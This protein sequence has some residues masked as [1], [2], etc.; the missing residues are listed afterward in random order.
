VAAEPGGIASKL[1]TFYERRFAV[2][3]ALRLT[4]GRARRLRWEPASGER[5]GADVEVD[6]DDG[7]TEHVQLRRQN[8]DQPRWTV[9]ELDAGGILTAAATVAA[10][11]PAHRFVFA[12][13]VPAQHL[14]DIC[15]RLLRNGDSPSRFVEERVRD[16]KG[17]RAAF[18]ELL[19]RWSL[20]P[21]SETDLATA[22]ARLG[23]MRFIVLDR[24]PYGEESLLN[25]VRLALSG[26]PDQT[27]ALIERFLEAQL[28]CDITPHSLLEH[29]A[30][31]DVRPRDLTS[32]RAIPAAMLSLRENF[33]ASLRERLVGG[34]WI[35]RSE[36]DQAVEK[37]TGDTPPRII[38]VHGKPGMGKSGVLLRLTEA[39]SA[40]GVPVLPISLAAT[41]PSGNA[42]R[43]GA[44]LGLRASPVSALRA[45]AGPQRAVLLLDQLDAL[46]FTTSASVATWETCQSLLRAAMADPDTV[47]VL[48][49][50]SFDLENDPN[51]ARW[52]DRTEHDAPGGV[53]TINVGMLSPEAVEPVVRGLGID[54]SALPAPLKRLL[55]HPA[56]LDAWHRLARRG[57]VR[58]D[59]TT[60]TALLAELLNVLRAEAVRDH[61][62]ADAEVNAV[63]TRARELM[64]SSGRLTLPER[65]FDD[66]H[67][68][69]RACCAAGLLVLT[70]GTV[71]FPHQSYFDHLV[72]RAALEASGSSEAEIIAWVK[73]DQSLM[74]RDRV[75]QL[76]V[77][78]RDEDRTLA[79]RVTESLLT[80]DAVRFHIKYLVLGVLAEA[81]PVGLEDV[82]L[83]VGLA[84]RAGW[85]DH[86]R[87]KVLWRSV[88]WFDALFEAGVWSG[89]LGAPDRDE[90]LAWLQV[91]CSVMEHRPEQIDALLGPVLEK[92]DGVDALARGLRHP[93]PSHDSPLVAA[94]R[95][96]EVSRGRW[97][98]H[99]VFLDR[100]ADRDPPRA[101]RLVVAGV[102]G[103]LRRALRAREEDER[104]EGLREHS[105][106]KGVAQAARAGGR[107][108][109]RRLA[110]VL[111]AAER[112]KAREQAGIS[113]LDD[114]DTRH[115]RCSSALSG[116]IGIVTTLTAHAF[117]GLAEREPEAFAALLAYP[118]IAR[119]E[120]LARAVAIGLG[121]A[122]ESVADRA[123]A[124]ILA[125][126][127]RLQLDDDEH[128]TPK[129]LA[130]S[131]IARHA[132]RCSASTLARLEEALLSHFPREEVDLY[133]WRREHYPDILARGHPVGRA[134]H[135]LLCAVPEAARSS[136]VRERIALWHAKFGDIA[137]EREAFKAT[138]GWVR[139]PIP[140]DRLPSVPDRQWIDIT[141]QRW[142]TRRRRQIDADSVAEA[143]PEHFA[144]D[145][146]QCARTDPA[147]FTKLMLRLPESAPSVFLNRLLD[148]LADK[149]TN[150]D[151]CHQKDL[152]AVLSIAASVG[153][154]GVLRS[155]CRIIE[156]HPDRAWGDDAWTLLKVAAAHDEPA[157]DQYTVYSN[158]GGGRR[159][160]VESTSLNCVRGG[161]ASA[162]G[163]LAWN[164][165]TR[166]L[167][168]LP[169]IE[170]LAHDPHPAVR[171]AAAHAAFGVYTVD[172][173][174]GAA[175]LLHLAAHDDDRLLAGMWVNRLIRH[176]R[177]SHPGTLEALLTRMGESD[178]PK[179]AEYG[180]RW[181]TAEHFQRGGA[182]GDAYR[183]CAAG[184][185]PQ[186]VG[187]VQTLCHLLLDEH[188]DRS[189]VE[190]AL[191]GYFNDTSDAVT[192][193]VD[194]VF[195][196]DGVLASD[197]G[198]RLANAYVR[199][200]AFLHHPEALVWPLAHD[201]VDLT[202]YAE[203]VQA[204]AE[205]F[206]QE[207]APH[208][209]SIQQ[210]LGLAGRDLSAML[211]RLY[212]SAQ[213]RGD[214]ELAESCLD[215]WDALLANRVGDAEKSLEG[216]PEG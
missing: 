56:A 60:H 152:E 207:L 184:A 179:V 166:M 158:E 4:T 40:Q 177:W 54:Y 160:D 88:A 24:G 82:G 74:C 178:D 130:E 199:S 149:A 9:A 7:V 42:D 146:G 151:A 30:G 127:A 211:L 202:P 31:H 97:G 117:A 159:A 198:P 168:A 125:D 122:L 154:A 69:L 41:P 102:E 81:H 200:P 3:Q 16:N 45:V 157:T 155:A 48:A 11:G 206:A 58:R 51:I 134:Q 195:R 46:R 216:L 36:P 23:A 113:S 192:V 28:G 39:L 55:R 110:R 66:H 164:N 209:R 112:V 116:A 193:A 19:R 21:A 176:T 156:S 181:I 169:L 201:K 67:V 132:G 32:D 93:D 96:R 101:L 5:G 173:D 106:E 129:S 104:V 139:S 188:S 90:R 114:L 86:L 89:W 190:S 171:A 187:V 13:S 148:A 167:M 44:D 208:T 141:Q 85:G 143:S 174:R 182:C 213:K 153:D 76:L 194:D 72:A 99:E 189:A 75:R 57:T 61:P 215:R 105:L 163:A 70:G 78:L 63:L 26:S 165:S 15:E 140:P 204:I 33:I 123:I 203:V 87:A 53:L 138:G 210:N 22:I 180:A 52:K 10:R 29:L 20:D 18:E 107:A 37:I 17:R 172:A 109:F 2:E 183:R 59:M 83:V 119:S 115:Y 137:T 197:A 142:S 126:P 124:W 121:S 147:R 186:R 49:C 145:F 214:R 12:S 77:L 131:I 79:A 6:L 14:C 135:E 118:G 150:L 120:A 94:V 92:K 191:R 100:L 68:A 95:E 103:L 25:Q 84:S 27:V 196:T 170:R 91:V 111:R 50:R 212:D 38:I 64:E 185:E 205:R 47:L 80:D 136:R 71:S 133:R 43:F 8:G 175:L 108:A 62:A 162:L 73:H 98:T 1:G 34:N 128:P 65:R 144:V 35:A 161:A